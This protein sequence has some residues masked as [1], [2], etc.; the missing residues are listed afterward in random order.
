MLYTPAQGEGGPRTKNLT[1]RET[2]N[3]HVFAEIADRDIISAARHTKMARATP[4]NTKA[5]RKEAKLK[6]KLGLKPELK[7]HHPTELYL[8]HR[9]KKFSV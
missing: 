9:R 3:E 2:C 6:Y 1:S 4:K 8:V 5:T 7:L